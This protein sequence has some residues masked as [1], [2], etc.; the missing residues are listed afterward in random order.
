[1][2]NFSALANLNSL[3]NRKNNLLQQQKRQQPSRI[4]QGFETIYELNAD[5][6]LREQILARD[7]AVRDCENDMATARDEGK[8]EGEAISEAR[9]VAKG[10]AEGRLEGLKKALANLIASGMEESQAKKILGL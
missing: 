4:R 10:K 5:V 9:G 3:P 7:K 8:A 2:K 6:A 1:M